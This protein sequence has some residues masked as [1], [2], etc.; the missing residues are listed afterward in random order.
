MLRGIY[1]VIYGE[2]NVYVSVGG[3]I[4]LDYIKK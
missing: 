2:G 1:S 3:E 4:K